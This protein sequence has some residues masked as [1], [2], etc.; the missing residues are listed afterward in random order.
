ME[1]QHDKSVRLPRNVLVASFVALAS[2]FGQDL[3]A[4]VLPAYLVL[5]G[6]TPAAIGL[7]DGL[8]QGATSLFRFVSGIVSDRMRNRKLL[9]LIGYALSSL[10]RPLL[11]LATSFGTVAGLR[12]ADGIGKGTKDAPRD[13]LI[14]DAAAAGMSGRAF[15]FHRFIDTAGSVIGPLVA[16]VILWY[17]TPVLASYRLI[18][19]LSAVPGAVAL[20][21]IVWGIIER[22][23]APAP[24]RPRRTLPGRFWV[25]TIAAAVAMLT[26][27]NDSL[28]LVRAVGLGVAPALAPVMFA[29]FTFLY[30]V[31]SYPLGVWSDRIGKMP[32]ILA[33]WLI[34]AITELGFSF[35]VPLAGAAVLFAL[36]G[37]FYA[38]TEGSI[39]AYVSEIVGPESRAYA[40]AVH[41]T[42][43]G[44]AVILGGYG[45]G[46][47]WTG[48][49]PTL[50]FRLSAAG[51][52]LAC[53]ILAVALW[54]RSAA[55]MSSRPAAPL[56]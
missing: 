56:I 16:A 38:L 12:L 46:R 42:L 55:P 13:A 26:K 39:R 32:L 33:G 5:L 25:F 21:L 9:V 10:A 40:F 28:F 23:T 36:Y 6:F 19:F 29:G 53:L 11:G 7:I 31:L 43:S 44:L 22:Q 37:L 1:T 8:L 49:S 14:A 47:I 3:I 30:A 15:G 41:H 2:G 35:H 48:Y 54:R 52:L 18:F 20:G 51:T 34:L 27:M 45:L 50:S 4:P 17:L 24:P